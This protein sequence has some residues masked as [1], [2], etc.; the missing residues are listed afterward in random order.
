MKSFLAKLGTVVLL[1]LLIL[2]LALIVLLFAGTGR[3]SQ[4]ARGM[5]GSSSP[6][7]ELLFPNLAAEEQARQGIFVSEAELRRLV[8]GMT[9][10]QVLA[11]LGPPQFSD[12]L[13]EPREW[14]YVIKPSPRA[15][16][17]EACRARIWFDKENRSS[18]IAFQPAGCAPM[19]RDDVRDGV[20]AAR[21]R[22]ACAPPHVEVRM[23]PAEQA[24]GRCRGR[25]AIG[26]RRSSIGRVPGR[27][28]ARTP[29]MPRRWARMETR[30]GTGPVGSPSDARLRPRRN[31][32][33]RSRP[34]PPTTAGKAWPSRRGP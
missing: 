14:S 6:I 15:P 33:R 12:G 27:R 7:S 24:S 30:I 26:S 22:S 5:T 9:R 34:R 19:A 4:L 31:R 18:G 29:C 21:R 13:P 11:L 16:V 25:R 1:V 8:L 32:W 20:A 10:R 28:C 23:P 17:A 2:A 3:A